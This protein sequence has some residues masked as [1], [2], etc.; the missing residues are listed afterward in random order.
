MLV[1]DSTGFAMR[2]AVE[3]W[4]RTLDGVALLQAGPLCSPVFDAEQHHA[5]ATGFG[6][7]DEPCRPNVA[8]GTDLVLIVDHGLPLAEHEHLPSGQTVSI[9]EPLL[10]DAIRRAYER[11][12]DQARGVG[13][14][15]VFLTPPVPLF[16]ELLVKPGA[17]EARLSIYRRLVQALADRPGV[18]VLDIGGRIEADATR[19]PRSDGLH[20]DDPD[21]AVKCAVHG[22]TPEQTRPLHQVVLGLALTDNYRA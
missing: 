13:A 15:V 18:H 4:V 1:G 11:T 8:D 21:G 10:G 3:G 17:A 16:P 5:W 2:H 20:L 6:T 22:I 7:M 12:I 19:Y 9:T 14:Q